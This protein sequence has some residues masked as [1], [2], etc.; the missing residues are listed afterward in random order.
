MSVLG[1]YT[2]QPNEIETYSISYN[3][4]LTVNDNLTGS[5]TVTV[6]PAG[7]VVDYST[8]IDAP[9]DHRVRVKV[10]G[11]TSGVKYKVTVLVNTA[12]GRRLEDEFYVKIKDY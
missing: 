2:K 5:A 1:N 3:D 12:D 6:A 7:L 11:G 9:G 10:S 4:D 8:V